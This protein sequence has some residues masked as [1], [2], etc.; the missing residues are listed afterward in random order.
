MTR[1]EK[2][3]QI[4]E[5]EQ[6]V[7]DAGYEKGKSEGGSDGGFDDYF[8]NRYLN[9]TDFQYAFAGGGWTDNTF[10]PNKKI[11]ISGSNARYMFYESRVKKSPY[12]KELDFS[13]CGAA[14]QIFCQSTV[15]ELG[16]LDFSNVVTGWG[17]LNQ[18][19]YSCS[20][21]RSIEKII[22]PNTVLQNNYAFAGCNALEEVRFEGKLFGYE[23][24]FHQNFQWCPLSPASMKS[25]IL[26]L[27]NYAGTDE[28]YC[29]KLTFTEECWAALAADS[30]APD[31]GTWREYVDSLGWD[32]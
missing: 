32:T 3:T 18:T 1:A 24:K 9:A 6:R 31:G 17:G 2:L 29:Y 27:N 16:V 23:N 26:C 22:M 15:E 4:A 21:L 20:N 25:I 13:Q 7:Y 8:W 30:T 11:P 5:N 10:K 28:A 19:F 14:V 12:L